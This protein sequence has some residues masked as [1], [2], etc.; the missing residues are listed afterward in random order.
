MEDG[1][2]YVDGFSDQLQDLRMFLFGA[3]VPED[4]RLC[5]L[6]YFVEIDRSYRQVLAG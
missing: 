5:F 3:L 1:G 2:L 6:R 4:D